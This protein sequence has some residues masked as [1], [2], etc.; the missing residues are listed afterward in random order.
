MQSNDNEYICQCQCQSK[1][2]LPQGMKPGSDWQG[3]SKI[4]AVTILLRAIRRFT[5]LSET[6]YNGNCQDHCSCSCQGTM[7]AIQSTQD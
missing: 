2:T 7:Q 5:P 6:E 4:M 1:L 3:K